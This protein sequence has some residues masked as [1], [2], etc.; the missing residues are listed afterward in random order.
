MTLKML[1]IYGKKNLNYYVNSI[2]DLYLN[3]LY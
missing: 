1:I 2:K 3:I